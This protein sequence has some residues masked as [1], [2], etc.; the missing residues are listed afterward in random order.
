MTHAGAVALG[1]RAA[2]APIVAMTEDHAF[3]DENWAERLLAA[4]E[5]PF[6]VVGPAIR[7][8]NPGTIVSW[9]DLYIRY[10]KWAAPVET[11]VIDLAMGHNGSYK[12]EALL[13]FGERLTT[14]LDAETVLQWELAAQGQKFWL[15]AST[16]TAHLN[17]ER[18][19]SWLDS[20]VYHA[21]VFAAQR[22]ARWSP[23]KRAAY[24]LGSPLIPLVRFVRVRRDIGRAKFAPRFRLP[25]YAV[26]L[27]GLVVDAAGQLLGYALGQGGG[28]AAEILMHEFHRERHFRQRA[29]PTAGGVRDGAYATASLER[30][31]P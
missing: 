15:E 10:G 12:R 5:G 3:P 26:C 17:Y 24:A 19:G 18:W 2:R 7:N 21:R 22:A 27:I 29:A 8:G 30:N 13:Q 6:A 14:L 20:L 1:V 4:H 9:G 11:G 16:V 31:A 28:H 25:L 23:L